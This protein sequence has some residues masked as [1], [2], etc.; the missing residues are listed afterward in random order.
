MSNT[1]ELEKIKKENEKFKEQ[2]EHYKIYVKS[3]QK[4][5][6]MI[7]DVLDDKSLS[8]EEKVAINTIFNTMTQ[9]LDE[10]ARS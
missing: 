3:W 4:S 5:R 8:K 6:A 2:I 10:V 7:N 1:D 9:A